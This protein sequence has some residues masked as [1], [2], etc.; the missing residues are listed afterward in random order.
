MHWTFTSTAC[1]GSQ[2]SKWQQFG[3]KL[4]LNPEPSFSDVTVL[5]VASPC[6]PLL[7]H[8]IEF[9]CST[10]WSDLRYPDRPAKIIK[11][12]SHVSTSVWED[13]KKEIENQ[14][15]L[16]KPHFSHC[17]SHSGSLMFATQWKI[18]LKGSRGE[19]AWLTQEAGQCVCSLTE[20]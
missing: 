5:T 3:Q 9:S 18:Q 7:N 12:K 8:H 10:L 13:R 16:G 19:H 20:A 14:K 4:K 17:V 1:S 15:A 11:K 2:T 6:Y